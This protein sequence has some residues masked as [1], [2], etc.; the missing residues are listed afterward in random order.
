MSGNDTQPN[1]VWTVSADGSTAIVTGR[2]KMPLAWKL[3]PVWWFKN[4]EEPLPPA[5]YYPGS[6]TRVIRWYL[7]NPLQNF[8]KY[9][10][11]VYDR[12][13]TV[14]GTAPVAVTTFDDV[15]KLGWKWSAI[16][17]GWRW[18]P[19]VSYSGKKVVWYAGWQYWGFFGL[20]FNVK[21]SPVQVA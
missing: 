3:N 18:L 21:N 14:F 9:V 7:R 5:D 8:G 13:Y 10:L 16:R 20:K 19:F 1:E 4:D 11:G 15:G 12:N 6:P 2:T 17:L